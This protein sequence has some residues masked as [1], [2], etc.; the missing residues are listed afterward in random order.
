MSSFDMYDMTPYTYSQPHGAEI[1]NIYMTNN[2]I[3]DLEHEESP[4]K[5][6]KRGFYYIEHGFWKEF[7]II[8]NKAYIKIRNLFIHR[9]E[10]DHQVLNDTCY[11]YDIYYVNAGWDNIEA[12]YSPTKLNINDKYKKDVKYFEY[13]DSSYIEEDEKEYTEMNKYEDFFYSCEINYKFSLKNGVYNNGDLLVYND[14]VYYIVPSSLPLDV[15]LIE[16]KTIFGEVDLSENETDDDLLSLEVSN[17]AEGYYNKLNDERK[18]EFLIDLITD[19]NSMDNF[20]ESPVYRGEEFKITFIFKEVIKM[21]PERFKNLC[22]SF[23]HY[24]KLKYCS[25]F[26]EKELFKVKEEILKIIP[27]DLK[28]YFINFIEDFNNFKKNYNH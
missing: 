27:V 28:T 15:K 3:N 14:F 24:N 4:L 21:I 17:Y 18:R 11:E 26:K 1:V 2:I 9:N 7:Y 23:Y 12:Y 16:F 20:L 25:L 22:E 6:G 5:I 8:K 19:F 13:N 10:V